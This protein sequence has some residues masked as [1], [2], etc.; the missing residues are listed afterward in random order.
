MRIV[1]KAVRTGTNACS[2]AL[3]F[4]AMIPDGMEGQ[5]EG[6]VDSTTRGRHAPTENYL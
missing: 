5:F 2:D 4:E 6:G 3:P 1:A